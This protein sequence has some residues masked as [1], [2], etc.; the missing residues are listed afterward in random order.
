M[1]A[2]KWLMLVFSILLFHSTEAAGIE[3]LRV[4]GFQ[5]GTTQGW[6]SGGANP[7]PPTVVASGGPDGAGDGYLRIEGSGLP[8]AGGNLVAFN[9]DQWSGDY[10]AAGVVAIGAT[11][12]NLGTTDLVIRLLFEGAGGSFVTAAAVNLPAGGDWER[13]VWPI[14][15]SSSAAGS[16]ASPD[17][18][19]ITK[20]R[21]LHAPTEEDLSPIAGMLGVDDVIGLSGHVC[22]DAELV[23]AGRALCR[24]YCERLDCDRRARPNR[25][26]RVIAR[27]FERRTGS[28]PPCALDADGDGWTDDLDNC[29]DDAN[30]DLSDRDGDGV[31]D[32]CDSCPD[33][34]NPDQDDAVCTCPCFTG[35]DVASLI[36]TLRESTTYEGL[37]CVDERP[38]TKPLTFVRAVRIDGEPCGFDSQDCSALAAEFT[39]DS[40]CQFNPPA[41]GVSVRGAEISGVQREACRGLIL[42]EADRAAL[43]CQ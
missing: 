31:G 34:S 30:P 13:A 28:P 6:R 15:A 2:V 32:V 43:A 10:A 21:I 4:D 33:A 7:N 20:L 8:S 16:G 25:A 1:A 27:H 40:V 5:D 14:A 17:L 9:T 42:T 26:C 36:E 23:G 38:G 35:D 24:V 22:R 12:R 18:S 29:P 3:A 39:E 19:A 41:P 11:V 37:A